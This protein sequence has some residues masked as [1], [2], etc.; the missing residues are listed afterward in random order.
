MGFGYEKL[1]TPC[2]RTNHN[3]QSESIPIPIPIPTP[4]PMGTRSRRIAN[5]WLQAAAKPNDAALRLD[6]MRKPHSETIR[7]K[8]FA[9]A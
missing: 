5:Y 9:G 3:S 8:P 4:T 2:V 1:A 6:L 7:A